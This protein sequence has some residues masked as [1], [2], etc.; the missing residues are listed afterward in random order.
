MADPLPP[1]LEYRLR[2]AE[3][4]L[5]WGRPRRTV[6]GRIGDPAWLPILG[7]VAATA[8]IVAWVPQPAWH[9]VVAA[10]FRAAFV[11]SAISLIATHVTIVVR[12]RR[13]VVYA[14]TRTRA[15]VVGG[16]WAGGVQTVDLARIDDLR[17]DARAG[18]EGTIWFGGRPRFTNLSDARTV[19]GIL[20]QAV[21]AAGGPRH[22]GRGT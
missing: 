12:Q 5:W 11:C 7:V 3:Q 8:V 4:V 9:P 21:V 15:M 10:I 16:Y 1:A 2:P 17:L 22:E 13:Q 20:Q 6:V 14:V 19:H 18:E